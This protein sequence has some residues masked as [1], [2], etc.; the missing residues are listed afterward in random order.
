MLA[1]GG[2]EAVKL[3]GKTQNSIQAVMDRSSYMYNT[4]FDNLSV[5]GRARL[6]AL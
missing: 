1:D 3:V 4:L 5:S 6:T 2:L